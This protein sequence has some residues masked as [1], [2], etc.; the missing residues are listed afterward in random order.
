MAELSLLTKEQ[1]IKIF[2]ENLPFL[3]FPNKWIRNVTLK[4]FQIAYNSLSN[5]D[6]FC[7]IRPAFKYYLQNNFLLMNR[8]DKYENY[9]IP[10]V[11]RLLVDLSEANI[12]DPLLSSSKDS[13][14]NQIVSRL[15]NEI[16]ILHDPEEKLKSY[17]DYLKSLEKIN[18]IKPCNFV[19]NTFQLIQAKEK[20]KKEKKLKQADFSSDRSFIID[21]E[22][23]EEYLEQTYYPHIIPSKEDYLL[24]NNGMNKECMYR[25][26]VQNN[27]GIWSKAY[28]K[29][30]IS[31]AL[32]IYPQYDQNAGKIKFYQYN[33]EHPWKA[34]RPQ[35]KLIVTLYYHKAPVTTIAT[36]ENSTLMATGSEDGVCCVWNSEDIERDADINPRNKFR[37]KSKISSIQYL[38][39]KT[40]MLIG[41]DKGSLKF[42]Q[43]D[44]ENKLKVPVY[45]TIKNEREGSIVG[46]CPP[47]NWNNQNTFVYATQKGI[48]HMH[49]TRVGK[50]VERFV[51]DCQRGITTCLCAGNDEY[52]YFMGTYGGYIGIY[53]IR[54]NIMSSLRKFSSG[55]SILDICMHSPADTSSSFSDSPGNMPL[56]FTVPRTDTPR[57]DLFNLTKQNSEWSFIGRHN[58][59]SKQPLI[60]SLEHAEMHY[61][62]SNLVGLRKLVKIV[63]ISEETLAEEKI[64]YENDL[65]WQH[66]A[67]TNFQDVPRLTKIIC[68]RIS[69]NGP[70]APCILAAGT[71]RTV[72]YISKNNAC[73]II[74][75]EHKE[76]QYHFDEKNILLEEEIEMKGYINNVPE[77]CHSDAVLNLGLLDLSFAT[78]LVTCGRDN[79]VKIWT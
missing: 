4:F 2:L 11:S 24:H 34:W 40:S 64:E 54:F 14:A 62:D 19:L 45:K 31:K 38:E 51:V 65:E 26:F 63:P 66:Q 60:N 71:D 56:V 55:A 44:R 59:S 3:V 73:M 36:S 52:S 68:P 61:T 79:A 50:D 17:E 8:E 76:Y 37:I 48:I 22:E 9:L 15:I 16:K 10:P 30:C 53:D 75:P 46:I 69:R 78:F 27:T 74:N 35:G 5:V 12:Q 33:I 29:L 32:H 77:I 18:E 43:I 1:L 41:T 28:K 25:N 42:K 7:R 47:R 57:I 6:I 58:F 21:S 13:N 23:I 20:A 39:G 72:R 70:T 67:S 49:D